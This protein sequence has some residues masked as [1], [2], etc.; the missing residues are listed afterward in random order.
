MRKEK[1][2]LKKARHIAKQS[3]FDDAK[4]TGV[5]WNECYVYEPIMS[6]DNNEEPACIGLPQ[7]IVLNKEGDEYNGGNLTYEETFEIFHMLK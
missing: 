3:I 5:I 4:Y 1:E 2:I 7:F 6:I